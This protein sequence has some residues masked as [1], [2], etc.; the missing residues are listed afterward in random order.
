[1]TLSLCSV[2]VE[3]GACSVQNV[4]SVAAGNKHPRCEHS[5]IGVGVSRFSDSLI[6]HDAQKSPFIISSFVRFSWQPL[7]AQV[8]YLCGACSMQ[9]S[10]SK[11]CSA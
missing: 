4:L 10:Q 7:L 3:L 9:N 5:I 8:R 11:I 1:M 2:C 6:Q